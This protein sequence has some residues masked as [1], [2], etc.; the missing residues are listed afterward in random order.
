MYGKGYRVFSCFFKM[1]ENGKA[2]FR[3]GNYIQLKIYCQNKEVNNQ[4]IAIGSFRSL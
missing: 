2:L 3:R 4:Y 1:S